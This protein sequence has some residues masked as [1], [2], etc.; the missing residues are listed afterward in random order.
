MT[1]CRNGA[2]APP[3]S[4]KGWIANVQARRFFSANIAINPRFRYRVDDKEW[5][6]DA[7]IYLAPNSE[8]GL[9]GG[10]APRYDSR[11]KEV[12]LRVFVGAAFNLGL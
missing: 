1:R 3:S 6:F 11:D 8:G 9:I 7:P 4:D 2:L 5:D 12:T 10:I